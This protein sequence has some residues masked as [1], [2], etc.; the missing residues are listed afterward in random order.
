MCLLANVACSSGG[1]HKVVLTPKMLPVHLRVPDPFK[2]QFKEEGHHT[3]ACCFPYRRMAK[4][5]KKN[6]KEKVTSPKKK[7]EKGNV[8]QSLMKAAKS[9]SSSSSTPSR[10]QHSH[11]LTHLKATIK[12]KD[13]SAARQADEINKNYHTLTMEE[14]RTVISDFFRQ[15]GRKSGLTSCCTQVVQNQQKAD[16]KSWSGYLTISQLMTKWG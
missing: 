15:G 7:Q 6:A 14:K 3:P 2:K 10:Q 16:D 4:A 11:F 5:P 8:K 13:A 9:A 12:S 1:E